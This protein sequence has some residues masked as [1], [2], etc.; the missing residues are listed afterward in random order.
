MLKV[1]DLVGGDDSASEKKAV[2]DATLHRVLSRDMLAE[3]VSV[4]EDGK[5]ESTIRLLIPFGDVAVDDLMDDLAEE[6]DRGRRAVLL[7]ILCEVARGH[8]HRVA[9]RLADPRWF[10]ARNA[11]TVLHRSGGKDVVPLLAEATR[12][13]EPAVRREAARGLLAVAGLEALPEL[14]MLAVDPDESV[15][16]TVI[17][18][19][20]GS[21]NPGAA[22]A[23]GRL[24]R[25]LHDQGDRRRAI[26]ALARHPAPEAVDT[27][28]ELA[29]AR[30]RPKLPFRVRR[31]AKS[32]SKRRRGGIA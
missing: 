24:V 12:H 15:R 32:L 8:H 22:A 3:L 5:A 10:V 11:V 14:M 13:Q 28:A 6:R 2:V 7:A 30:S 19:M 1:M 17:S 9:R 31:Y 4:A 18:A 26:D 16:S 20:G 27:L 29:S 21:S 23:L 25:T